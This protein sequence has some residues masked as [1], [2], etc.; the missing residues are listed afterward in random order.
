MVAVIYIS[1]VMCP[2]SMQT[3]GCVTLPRWCYLDSDFM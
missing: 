2:L 1:V 3:Q